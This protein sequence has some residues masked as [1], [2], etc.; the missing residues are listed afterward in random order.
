MNVSVALFTPLPARLPIETLALNPRITSVEIASQD[1]GWGACRV[2]MADD[3]PDGVSPY[4][5]RPVETVMDGMHVEVMVGSA[6]VYEGFLAQPRIDGGLVRGLAFSGYGPGMAHKMHYESASTAQTTAL[7]IIR[8]A[9]AQ[10][11]GLFSLA[12]DSVDTGAL[13]AYREFDGSNL[14]QILTTLA[15]EGD[16]LSQWMWTVYA[17]RAI[18]FVPRRPADMP[19]YR[20]P[21]DRRVVIDPD[22]SGV[23]DAARL[24]DGELLTRWFYAP[25]MDASNARRRITL[26]GAVPGMTSA[27]QMAQT[28]IAVHGVPQLSGAVSL[29]ASDE[30][31]TG[32]GASRAAYLALASE[33][34][35]IEGF[36]AALI[37]RATANLTTRAVA[38]ALGQPS[39]HSLEGLLART[40]QTTEA[41]RNGVSPLTGFST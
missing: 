2:G 4:L 17:G 6:L 27:N 20:L 36:G 21:V 32:D 24:R 11:G 12:P 3:A 41:V 22:Y 16:G 14:A 40:V 38:L 30:L 19:T 34:V 1:G 31:P 15:T 25:G 7:N 33:T 26:S 13:H 23:Y 29:G 18:R 28:W 37:E 5:P 39:A 9:V 35:S 10:T 8:D